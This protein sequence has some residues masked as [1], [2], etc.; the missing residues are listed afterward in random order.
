MVK[1]N[2]NL[3]KPGFNPIKPNLSP[4]KKLVLTRPGFTI[5][6]SDFCQPNPTQPGFNPNQFGPE[7]DLCTSI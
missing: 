4:L 1:P 2:L 7:P 6:G 5:Y 3:S